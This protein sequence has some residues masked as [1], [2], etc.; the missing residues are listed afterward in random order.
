VEPHDK[1]KLNIWKPNAICGHTGGFFSHYFVF[2]SFNVFIY[3]LKTPWSFYYV[4]FSGGL[5]HEKLILC[6]FEGI[7]RDETC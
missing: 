7:G 2:V 5:M 6:N 3:G 4:A 1:N